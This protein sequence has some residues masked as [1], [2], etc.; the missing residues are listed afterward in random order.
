MKIKAKDIA[1]SLGVST[2]AVSLALNNKPGIGEKTRK[3]ILAYYDGIKKKN[4][5]LIENYSNIM[6]LVVKKNKGIVCDS[7]IDIW[8]EVLSVFDKETKKAGYG[9]IIT[10]YDIEIDDIEKVKEQCRREDIAG[11]ILVATEMERDEFTPFVEIK[12]PLII[13]DN[14]FESL[15]YDSI[16]IN[17]KLGVK[18]AVEF[19]INKGHKDIIYI[20]NNNDIYNFFERR[21]G[22]KEGMEENR[23]SY[24][25]KIIS[26]GSSI[27]EIYENMLDY[28]E[29]ND[30]PEA[31]IMENY[32]VSIGVIKALKKKKISIPEKISL[33]GIDSL[34]EHTIWDFE[35][36]VVKISHD[37]RA[38]I[39][40]KCIFERINNEQKEK[41]QI[42]VATKFSFGN[43]IK[44][45]NI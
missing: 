11:I 36:D 3:K 26:L 2:A 19:L 37:K 17:N 34:P 27:N 20:K 33:L 29:K 7:G 42:S 25:S 8:S 15:D 16:V 4:K 38:E 1:R 13:Y 14:D 39:A 12:K 41:I 31:F 45:K 24:S 22:F 32:Q 9:L 30:V 10:Y 6:I 28:I 5:I 23:L 18:K 35:L 43:S 44:D 21:K 40:M